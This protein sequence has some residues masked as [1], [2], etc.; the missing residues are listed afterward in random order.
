MHKPNHHSERASDAVRLGDPVLDRYLEFVESRA[1]RNTVLAGAA[2]NPGVPAYHAVHAGVLLETQ[3]NQEALHLLETA[4]ADGFE[5]LPLDVAWMD[6]V[7][8]NSRAAFDLQTREPAEMLVRVLAPYHDQVP[9]TGLVPQPPV[10]THLGGLSSVL[11]CYDEAESYFAQAAV[12][13]YPWR[14]EVRGGVHQLALATDA[15]YP[16]RAG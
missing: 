12:A 5:S 7:I 4:A 2:D 15:S 13:Q 9:F 14:D 8:N 1:R 11:G 10:A 16:Q 6:A 3:E